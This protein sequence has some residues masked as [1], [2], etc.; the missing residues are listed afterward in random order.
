L[1]EKAKELTVRVTVN[2]SYTHEGETDHGIQR[3]RGLLKANPLLGRGRYVGAEDIRHC[4]EVAPDPQT[5]ARLEEYF[6]ARGED[7]VADCI[8][9]MAYSGLRIGEALARRRSE[10]PS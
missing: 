7:D 5:L 6:R 8:L 2:L 10:V 9:F 1:D 3:R 4:R